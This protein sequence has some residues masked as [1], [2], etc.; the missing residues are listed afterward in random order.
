MKL[1][2]EG[3]GAT[4]WRDLVDRPEF[5]VPL[6]AVLLVGTA[7]FG[8]E[9]LARAELSMG[10]E[11]GAIDTV[12][13]FDATYARVAGWVGEK[14]PKENDYCDYGYHSLWMGVFTQRQYHR[15]WIGATVGYGYTAL[16]MR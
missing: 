12:G 8:L 1:L 11:R 2:E 13:P 5:Q 14:R 9:G 6:E 4:L 3:A 15:G 16:P 10:P 7:R